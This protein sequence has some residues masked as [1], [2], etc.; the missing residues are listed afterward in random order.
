[1]NFFDIFPRQ[2]PAVPERHVIPPKSSKI[3]G[4][5]ITGRET[6]RKTPFMK[7]FI[8]FKSVCAQSFRVQLQELASSL[9][10]ERESARICI[11]VL[12]TANLHLYT[13]QPVTQRL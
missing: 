9:G 4:P 1:M 6:P 5:V 12:T 2:L 13:L 7:S 10:D 11:T 3:L 8:L